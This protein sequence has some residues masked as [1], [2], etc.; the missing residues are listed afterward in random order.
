MLSVLLVLGLVIGLMVYLSPTLDLGNVQ[1]T[2]TP[3]RM[4]GVPGSGGEGYTFMQVTDD[5]SPI[6][7]PCDEVIEIE[8]NPQGA[9]DGYADLVAGAVGRLNEVSGFTFEV[10]GETDDREFLGRGRGPV[11]LGWADE[12]EVPELTGPTAG[13]G[14]A[15]YVIGP[16]GAARSVGGMVVLDTDLPGFWLG[17]LDEE[18]VILHELIHV[19]GLGHSQDPV[20]LMAAENSGQDELG[21]GDLAGLAALE[22]AT[23]G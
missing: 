10:T 11:L 20:Q 8:V 4:D 23:C 18:T 15:A 9:P 17:G 21:E 3:D 22:E 2:V 12:A 19:L 1:R 16:G 7:W 6:T 14:G 5:G 13:L